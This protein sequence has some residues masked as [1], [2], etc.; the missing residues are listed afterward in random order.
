M[1][2]NS[3]TLAPDLLA[4]LERAPRRDPPKSLPITAYVLE[5]TEEAF[6]GYAI[7]EIEVDVDD[8]DEGPGWVT[9]YEQAPP[10]EAVSVASVVV[11]GNKLDISVI[12]AGLEKSQKALAADE[13][14]RQAKK[15]AEEKAKDNA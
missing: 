11:V 7:E 1:I 5:G 12:V 14:E 2:T 15:E 13:A 10:K 4:Y 9:G 6:A 8:G 3:P